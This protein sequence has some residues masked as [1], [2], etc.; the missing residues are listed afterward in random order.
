MQAFVDTGAQQ[1]I[2]SVKCAERCGIMRLVDRRFSGTVF[3]YKFKIY[4]FEIIIYLLMLIIIVTGVAKGVGTA[5]II[6]RVHMAPIQIGKS[7]FP[8]SFTILEDQDMEFILGLDM[9]RRHQCTIDLNRNFLAIGS[10]QAEFLA[11]KDIPDSFMKESKD[12]LIPP[13]TTSTPPPAATTSTFV[14]P[15][16]SSSSI[17]SSSI[18]PSSSAT[19]TSPTPVSTSPPA[20]PVAALPNEQDVQQLISI[21]ATREEV[22]KFFNN[23]CLLL[24]LYII[25]IYFYYLK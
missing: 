23:K 22:C 5:R 6:G 24:F 7:F 21:G 13:P 19:S 25:Y 14:P 3:I 1:T 18:P 2:M 9:L 16:S 4:I 12:D 8:C 10:E 17:P 11:E 20:R 15:S